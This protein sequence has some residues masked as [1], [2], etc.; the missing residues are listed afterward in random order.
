M[1]RVVVVVLI[2]LMWLPTP[3]AASHLPLPDSCYRLRGIRQNHPE[4]IRGDYADYVR[5]KLRECLA[6]WRDLGKP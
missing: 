6:A 5:D 4:L 3:A 1:H 2:V